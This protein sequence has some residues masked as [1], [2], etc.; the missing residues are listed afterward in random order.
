MT[1]HT[2]KA[3]GDTVRVGIIDASYPPVLEVDSG[4]EVVFETWQLWGD[5]VTPET[6]FEDVFAMRE[7]YRDKGPHSLTG[8]VAV[9][10]ARPGMALRV[11]ILDYQLRDH[12]FNVMLPRGVGRG[13][14][15]DEFEGGQIRHFALDST[16]MTTRLGDRLTVHLKPFLGIMGVAPSSPEPHISSVPGDFGGNID[17]SELTVG[18][19]LYLPV[20]V[21]G[22]RFYVGDAHAV[23]GCGEVNQMAI[24]T[25]MH[26]ARLRL[27]LLENAP[28]QRPRIDTG[29]HIITMGFDPDLREAARQAVRDMIGLL[30]AEYGIDRDDAYVMCSLKAD[31]II[32]QVVNGNNGVHAKLAREGLPAPIAPVGAVA[33]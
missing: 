32:T 20:W 19:T 33:V 18:A 8:P 13:L 1:L 25:A 30:V 15:A 22:A 12:G 27:S 28:L 21:D 7:Q 10:G 31:L 29:S 3:T 24:E 23:Q 5:A 2:L 26:A 11:D 9:R 4:D 16:T 17:C 6:S 14:L